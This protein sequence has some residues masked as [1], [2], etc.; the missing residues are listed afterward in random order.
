MQFTLKKKKKD[1]LSYI[2]R[3]AAGSTTLGGRHFMKEGVYF[4]H[5]D[6]VGMS[7][8]SKKKKKRMQPLPTS[9]S[10]RGVQGLSCSPRSQPAIIR[11][12]FPPVPSPL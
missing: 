12:L 11:G 10:S 8:E 9:P 7:F 6:C 3:L 5:R 1:N 4:P 2:R